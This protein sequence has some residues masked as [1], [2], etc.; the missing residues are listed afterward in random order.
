[1]SLL[2]DAPP[3][4][5]SLP[6]ASRQMSLDQFR[7]RATLLY[8]DGASNSESAAPR[9]SL[10]TDDEAARLEGL[11]APVAAGPTVMALVTRA[12]MTTFG[13]GWIR[14]GK[15]SLKM[16][17]PVYAQDFV[18]AKGRLTETS[19]EDGRTRLSFEV[20]VENGKHEKVTVGTASALLPVPR[21]EP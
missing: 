13:D 14:G 3:I 8:R 4:G 5:W 12:M 21:T 15:L 9:R 1:M 17:R 7:A 2:T 20:W 11:K 19:E 10:H 18:T 6:M 16:I